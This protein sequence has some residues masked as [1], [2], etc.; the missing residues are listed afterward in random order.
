MLLPLLEIVVRPFIA[1]GI[2][3]SISIVQHLTLWVAFLGAALAAREGK[4]IALATATFIPAGT[5]RDVTQIF[6]A[7]VS[8]RGLY[9]SRRWSH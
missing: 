3:G 5:V 4:L 8:H 2:P 9:D 6:S 7:F 1:G